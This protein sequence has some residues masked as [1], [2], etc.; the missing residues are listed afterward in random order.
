MTFFVLLS[1][2]TVNSCKLSLFTDVYKLFT[3]YPREY[4]IRQEINRQQ[5][6][7]NII[8]ADMLSPGSEGR[9]HTHERLAEYSSG[10]RHLPPAQGR[11][12][13]GYTSLDL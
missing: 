4:G 11:N 3:G 8:E 10:S 2:F 5:I 1:L 13:K 9:W 12:E 7:G 6:V